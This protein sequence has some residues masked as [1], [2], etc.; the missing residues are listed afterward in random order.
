MK[1]Y[2]AFL[3][4]VVMFLMVTASASQAVETSSIPTPIITNI[5][6]DNGE[7][8]RQ[9]IVVWNNLPA[10][11]HASVYYTDCDGGTAVK[12]NIKS[13]QISF[14]NC[15]DFISIWVYFTE[16]SPRADG[17]WYSSHGKMYMLD[18][19]QRVILDENGDPVCFGSNCGDD[20]DGDDDDDGGNDPAPADFDYTMSSGDGPFCIYID[21]N[22][23]YVIT[24]PA[25]LFY[26]YYEIWNPIG[27]GSQQYTTS[28]GNFSWNLGELQLGNIVSIYVVEHGNQD[29][30]G[31]D[32]QIIRQVKIRVDVDSR[33][34]NPSCESNFGPNN[35]T[36][37]DGILRGP[38]PRPWD[39]LMVYTSLS[40][41]GIR[42]DNPSGDFLADLGDLPDAEIVFIQIV[43]LG[44]QDNDGRDHE[45][46]Y[47]LEVENNASG[48]VPSTTTTT[49]PSNGGSSDDGGGG[50]SDCCGCFIA[51][52]AFGYA[53]ATQVV[54]LS[55]F[56]DRYLLTNS[57]GTAFVKL[58]YKYSP[59]AAELISRS[60]ILRSISRL[61]LAPLYAVAKY[62]NFGSIA[63]YLTLLALL[64]IGGVRAIHARG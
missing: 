14:N 55:E 62:K 38:F 48:S 60:E 45:V 2:K 56:R 18:N 46:F 47:E 43:E 57:V 61:L 26:N 52:A 8:P 3:L 31:V 28:S 24:G 63:I 20:G 22:D 23:D 42:V 16:D 12:D 29:D 54:I 25:P 41:E 11:C 5:V 30:D 53:Q 15:G 59:A 64:V 33:S 36:L 19:V 44:N 49:I 13:N 51:T 9:A 10:S 6:R 34:N 40:S 17:L 1:G 37:I 32:H 27:S 39:Y 58:Y 35:F 4:V 50:D 7:N 21:E